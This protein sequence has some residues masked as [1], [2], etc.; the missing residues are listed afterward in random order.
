MSI[1]YNPRPRRPHRLSPDLYRNAA[2][3][4]ALLLLCLVVYC[5]VTGFG[6]V[7]Y[8]D[9]AYVYQNGAVLYGLNWRG[10]RWA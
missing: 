4:L 8:D 2:A 6:F 5:R 3:P 1:P 10:F 7:T 9:G